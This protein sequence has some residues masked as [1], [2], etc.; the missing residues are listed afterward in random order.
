[1]ILALPLP[2][3]Q[4][5]RSS[6]NTSSVAAAAPP[7]AAPQQQ[8]TQ[9]TQPTKPTQQLRSS[10]EAALQH[11]TAGLRLTAR[12]ARP[13]IFYTSYLAH[14]QAQAGESQSTKIERST[15]RWL[16]K[17]L[18]RRLLLCEPAA[19]AAKAAA[20]AAK[21]AAATKAAA[22]PK[23]AAAKAADAKAAASN[24]IGFR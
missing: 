22:A 3:Q 20:A 12:R 19:A 13:Y 6:N 14:A 16:E 21:A 17:A 11:S 18:L 15:R 7:P 8:P 1:L 2:P 5:L 23:A 4:S 9:P 24:K 10:Y